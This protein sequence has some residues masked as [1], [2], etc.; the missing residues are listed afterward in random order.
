M[1]YTRHQR[2]LIADRWCLDC[3][4]VQLSPKSPYRRCTQCRFK[5]TTMFQRLKRQ[6]K[7]QYDRQRYQLR[8]NNQWRINDVT[9]QS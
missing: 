7:K 4:Q 3:E 2:A 8:K 6:A 1:P 5:K 9:T